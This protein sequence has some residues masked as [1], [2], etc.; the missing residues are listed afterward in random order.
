MT[1]TLH[2]IYTYVCIA[3]GGPRLRSRWRSIKS[4]KKKKKILTTICIGIC[5]APIGFSSIAFF[6]YVLWSNAFHKCQRVTYWRSMW[7]RQPAT[8][9]G[10]LGPWIS[11]RIESNGDR[12]LE[13]SSRTQLWLMIGRKMPKSKPWPVDNAF[14]LRRTGAAAYGSDYWATNG[15]AAVAQFLSFSGHNSTKVIDYNRCSD[16]AI[17]DPTKCNTMKC[18]ERRGMAKAIN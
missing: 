14:V 5:A 8:E 7:Q 13:C 12:Q 15:T 10:Y 17:A 18:K 2:L 11:D 9:T 3:L 16:P 1:L 6:R 4:K